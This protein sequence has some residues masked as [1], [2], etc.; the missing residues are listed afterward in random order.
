VTLL[1]SGLA[2]RLIIAY[3]LPGS[4]LSFDLSAFAFWANDLAQHGAWGFY[5]RPFFADYTPGYLYAL[6]AMGL[7]NEALKQIGITQYG[8][9]TVTDLLKMPSILADLGVAYLIYAMVLDLGAS[10]RRALIGAAI[11]L[12]NPITWFDSTVW[13]QVDSFG[14]L[15]LMLGLRELWRDRPERAAIYATIAAV[16]KPQLGILVPIVAAVVIRRYLF[17]SHDDEPSRWD[18]ATEAAKSRVGG[19]LGRFRASL[20]ADRG[21][22][23]IVTTAV[24]GL[25]TA[26]ILSLPFGMTIIDLVEQVAKTAGGYPYLTVNAFNPW[27]LLTMNGQGMAASSSWVRDIDGPDPGQLGYYFGPIPALVV[28]TILLLAVFAVVAWIVGRRPDRLTILVGLTVLAVAFF[29]VPTRVHERYLY[30]FFAF[31]AILAAVSFRWRLAYIVLGVACFLNMYVVLTTFYPNNP[32]ISDWL[33]IGSDIRSQT[34][35]TILALV[36]LAGFVWVFWQI[37][38]RAE[39]KLLAEIEIGRATDEGPL[40]EV[41]GGL[42][43][44][45]DVDLSLDDLP[46]SPEGTAGG[47]AGGVPVWQP[48]GALAGGGAMATARYRDEGLFAAFR[49]AV[50]ARPVR[51]D[52]SRAIDGESTGRIDRLD[53]WFFIVV[54][55]AA[56]TLRTFR[57]AEPYSM[58]FDEVYHARTATEFLQDWRYGIPHDIYEYTHPHLAKYMMAAGIVAFGDNQVTS[59][60]NLGVPVRAAAI[61]GRWDDPSLPNDRAGDRVYIATGSEVRAYDLATRE[62]VATIPA[63]GAS[64]V[65]V[66][67]ALHRLYIG[68]DSGQIYQVD[69]SAE[70]DRIRLGL[71]PSTTGPPLVF[72]TLKAPVRQLLVTTGST[73][74]VAATAD[75]KVTTFDANT[76][77]ELATEPQ[78]GVVSLVQGASSQQVIAIPDA[79]TNKQALASV[80]AQLLGGSAN[81]ILA[82]LNGTAS[83]VIIGPAPTASARASFDQ[84]YAD[85]KLGGVSIQA[86]PSIGA[87]DGGGLSLLVPSTMQL[88]QRVDIPGASGAVMATGLDAPRIYVAAGSKT[89]VVR[90]SNDSTATSGAY[91]ETQIPMPGEAQQVAYD[92]STNFIHVLGR[93]PDGSSATVYVIETH[94]NAVFADAKLPFDPAAFVADAQPDYPSQ[95]RQD[96]LTFAA[97][98]STA[99]VDIGNNPFAWRFPGVILGALTAGLIYILARLLFKRRS[100]AILAGIL[101][102]ADGMLFVQSRI[103]MNDVYVGFFIVAA[104]TLFAALWLGHLKRRWAFWVAMPTIGV[105]LGL[106]LASKWVGLYAMIGIGIL[107]LARSAL[108]RLVIILGMIV[109]TTFLGYMSLAVPNGA[110]SGG[111]LTFVVIMIALTIASVLIAVLHP[112]RW[113]VEEVRFAIAAPAAVGIGIV[114]IALPLG[115]ASST[116]SAGP[117][118]VSAL[119]IGL[120]FVVLA[121]VVAGAFWLAGR[122]GF[123]PLAPPLPPDVEARIGPATTAPEGWQR[124][125]TGF[126]IPAVWMGFSLLLLPIVVYVISYIPWFALGNQFVTGIPPGNHG[127]TLLQL[128]EQMYNYHNDLRAPHAASSPWWAWPLDLKPVWFYQGSF[129]GNTAGS[130][131]DAG[132]IVL[133]WLSIPAMAFCAFQAYRRRSLALALIVLAYAWQWLPWARIDRASFQYHYYTSVPFIVLALAYFLAELWHG[134]SKRTWLLAKVAAAVAIMGPAILWIGKG[135]LCRYV[136]VEAVNPGSQACVGNPGDLVVTARVAALVLVLGIA[137]VLI[138]Y[139]LMRLGRGDDGDGDGGAGGGGAGTGGRRRVSGIQLLGLGLTA[140]IVAVA[141]GF[142]DQAAGQEVVFQ[143]LGF[144]STYLALL[145]AVPLLLMALLVLTARD[146]RRFAAGTV[147]AIV[148]AFLILYPNI[149]ALPLPSTIVNAYQGLVPTYLYPFQFPVNTDPAVSNFKFFSLEPAVLLLALSVTCLVVGYAAWVWRIGPPPASDGSVPAGGE[150]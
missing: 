47:G 58:H 115:K 119:E 146:A 138:V 63:P 76:G 107:V 24:A 57:L 130:I 25:L 14:V 59:Q 95:D 139:Q 40:G 75:D 140:V 45:V 118:K 137:L 112:V 106:A 141:I 71:A 113:T 19:P 20:A 105:L 56:L 100:I 104:Y 117:F 123:G 42:P 120:A 72:A 127:Q 94:G 150:A 133:W 27:A 90:L 22:L 84:A 66:D 7:V 91:I 135:P 13:G 15:F 70:L 21:P 28:G 38:R 50:F 1:A 54:V 88:V 109:G 143:I 11:F 29:V 46:A 92:P 121:G 41:V 77:Q 122:F 30:P 4:G 23:R 61:E 132:N 16:I 69:T 148:A 147:F 131:Y 43:E 3:L 134:A 98:G 101:A 35:I 142:V 110:T 36:N 83:Q 82:K 12:F 32:N 74:V 93:T 102:L 55:I 49:N 124:L 2:L 149:S 9:W 18:S 6:W 67:E 5:D 96:L 126:G 103:G 136:R 78:A 37:R 17:G 34:T 80:L 33:G 114:L 108:G 64:S 129:A 116:V 111:N 65:T 85:G 44:A 10:K 97:D 48:A 128:T 39:S 26:V 81:D 99:S 62:Q 86:V 73:Y 51:A 68:T 125:G 89:M 144:Q 31:G 60:G 87:L 52:R 145:L 8:P 53:V 79:V